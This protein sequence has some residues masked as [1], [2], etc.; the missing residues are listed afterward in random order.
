MFELRRTKC[1]RIGTND[2]E[3]VEKAAGAILSI[4]SMV[5][6][7]LLGTQ[8]SHPRNKTPALFPPAAP[9]VIK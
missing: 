5:S 8:R 3:P 9:V 2:F 1:W 7:K 4:R 6:R